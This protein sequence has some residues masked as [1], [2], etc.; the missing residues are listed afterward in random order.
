METQPTPRLRREDFKQALQELDTFIDISLEDLL[1][2][3]EKATQFARLRDRESLPVSSIMTSPVISVAPTSSLARAAHLLVTERISGLPVTDEQQHLLGIITEADFLSAIGIPMQ[4][5][6]HSV[7]QTL[8]AIFAHHNT[9]WEPDGKV[10]DLMVK[11][12][13]S[14]TPEASLHDTVETMKQHHIKRIVVCDRDDRVVGMITRSDL[15]RVFFDR[16]I[17]G[18]NAA[19]KEA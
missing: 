13:I 3:N 1:A 7:W 16:F 2:I 5:A 4:H 8:E 15:V 12:V 11:Q 14:L 10:Q 18:S 17:S 19:A 6:S 9:V